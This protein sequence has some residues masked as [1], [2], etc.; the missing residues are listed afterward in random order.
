MS[1]PGVDPI[2]QEAPHPHHVLVDPT[3]Q[4]LLVID[5]GADQIRINK[6]DA[7]SGK[8]TE[9]PSATP[10]PGSG[11]RHAAFW[12]P[13]ASYSRVSRGKEG[14]K[15]FVVNELTNTVAGWSVS[16]PAG[17][18]LTLALKQTLT[19]YQGNSSAV[20]GTSVGEIKVKDNFLYNTNR[21]DTKFDGSDSITQYTIASDGTLTWTDITSTYG[22]IPRTFDINK[23][24]DF[25]AFGNQASANIAIVPRDRA[26]GKLGK[27]VANLRV[28]PTG[29]PGG[30]EGISAV[31][32]QE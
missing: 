29:T 1:G 31:V 11:I 24:G 8:L 4:F 3:G 27:R 17:G 7:A 20:A 14:T 12:T 21:N 23:R 30:Y 25:V 10:A 19:P 16:Y 28:G 26:T 2:R 18:C 32:W 22:H 6:I 9:C 13:A 5:L 15:L